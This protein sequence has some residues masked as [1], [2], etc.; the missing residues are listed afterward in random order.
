[1][2]SWNSS[3]RSEG[4]AL[5]PADAIDMPQFCSTILAAIAPGVCPSTHRTTCIMWPIIEL[6]TVS[7]MSIDLCLSSRTSSW[8]PHVRDRT[9][10][11]MVTRTARFLRHRPCRIVGRVTMAYKRQRWHQMCKWRMAIQHSSTNWS[12]RHVNKH[13]RT[14]GSRSLRSS[15]AT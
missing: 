6:A 14:S 11:R 2:N 7:C 3:E 5:Q 10:R 9:A 8:E 4:Q 12:F 13:T 15:A 1:M